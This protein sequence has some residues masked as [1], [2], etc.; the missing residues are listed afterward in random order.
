MNNNNKAALIALCLIVIG[1]GIVIAAR[2]KTPIS[3]TNT[4][5]QI[6]SNSEQKQVQGLLSKMPTSAA[7]PDAALY[8]QE[9]LAA[10]KSAA[11][12][13]IHN[14]QMTPPV[15]LLTNSSEELVVRNHDQQTHQLSHAKFNYEIAASGE[16]K[17]STK[18][19]SPGIYGYTCDDKLSGIF[20]V[21]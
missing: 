18:F 4:D 9:V 1:L 14:C 10:A 3:T 20:L 15:L 6:Q 5:Q 17:V 11:V 16:T 21:Q 12:L 19:D 2:R 13:E 7:S 8:S